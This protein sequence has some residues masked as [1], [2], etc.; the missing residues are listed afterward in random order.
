ME[1]RNKGN[2]NDGD[3]GLEIGDSVN[4]RCCLYIIVNR[5]RKVF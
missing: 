3:G 2:M 1:D 4:L 5:G